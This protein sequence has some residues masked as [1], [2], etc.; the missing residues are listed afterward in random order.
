MYLLYAVMLIIIGI[1]LLFA[2]VFKG[3]LSACSKI[4]GIFFIFVGAYCLFI[5]L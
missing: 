5:L 3:I 1:F 2:K 4:A